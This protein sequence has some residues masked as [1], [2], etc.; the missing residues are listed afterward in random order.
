[1]SK[2]CVKSRVTNNMVF[3]PVNLVEDIFQNNLGHTVIRR[4]GKENIRVYESMEE[5]R[6]KVDVA[7]GTQHIR[8]QQA[9]VVHNTVVVTTPP[10]AR[11]YRP[12]TRSADIL[13][14]AIG[15]GAGI[16]IG[17]VVSDFLTGFF[18]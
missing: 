10:V 17:D 1:M 7:L 2:I 18:D 16:V 13:D 4:V 11:G 15:V 8:E 3:I 9:Q 12:A 6:R 14:T 5:V